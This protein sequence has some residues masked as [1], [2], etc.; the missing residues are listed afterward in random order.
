M[1]RDVTCRH[2]GELFAPVPGKPGYINE[3]PECLFTKSASLNPKALSRLKDDAEVKLEK[4]LRKLRRTLIGKGSASKV[5][6]ADELIATVRQ[7]IKK[8]WEK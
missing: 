8:A 6:A 4:E 7:A 1:Q 5:K 3:C 2:C